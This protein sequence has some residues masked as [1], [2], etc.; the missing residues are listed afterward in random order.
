MSSFQFFTPPESR[1]VADE[2]HYGAHECC[3]ATGIDPIG[4]FPFSCTIRK[5]IPHTVHEAAGALLIV[6]RW[7]E[8]PTPPKGT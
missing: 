8:P 4:G 2:R 5:N 6:A 7:E 1:P 3:N